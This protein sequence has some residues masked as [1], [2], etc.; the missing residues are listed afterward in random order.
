[1]SPSFHPFVLPFTIGTLALFSILIIKYNRWISKFDR[2]QKS[3][4]AA[5][6]SPASL[7]LLF[8]K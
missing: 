2:Q 5:I 3:S 6:C 4:Y 1:M 7:Y 8:G